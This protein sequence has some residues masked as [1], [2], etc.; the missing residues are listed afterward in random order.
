VVSSSS[1]RNF[2]A[3]AGA[4]WCLF[5]FHVCALSAQESIRQEAW[6][7]ADLKYSNEQPHQN[8][9]L[10]GLHALGAYDDNVLNNNQNRLGDSI[11]EGGG[12]LGFRILRPRGKM[13]ITYRPTFELHRQF[14][15]NDQFSH[16]AEFSGEYK[17]AP[18]FLVN[19]SDAFSYR[20]GI[21]QP[22]SNG[23]T[24]FLPVVPGGLNG[25]VLVPLVRELTNQ[26]RVG[27]KFLW[28]RRSA[29]DFVGT[30]SR[31]DFENGQTVLGKLQNTRGYG[32]GAAYQYRT[33]QATTLGLRY[34]Y[35]DLRFGQGSQALIHS[36]YLTLGY[37]FGERNVSL[38]FFGGPQFA[39]SREMPFRNST[40]PTTPAPTSL[41]APVS[42]FHHDVGG[43]ATFTARSAKTVFRISLLRQLSDGGGVV[44]LTRDSSEGVEFRRRLGRGFDLVLDGTNGQST[45]FSD[46]FGRGAIRSQSAGIAFEYPLGNGFL[47]HVGYTYIRQRIGGNIPFAFDLDRNRAALGFFYQQGLFP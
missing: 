3:P 13:L 21:I 8:A 23:N 1:F 26:A 32:G 41:R 43:G 31:R 17:L 47:F 36:G 27:A 42:T 7:Q 34:L 28:S 19:A 44:A 9:F 2:V 15:G 16:G 11:L 6:D 20:K 30:Y 10:L 24:A 12:L 14:Q 29:F 22:S 18:H 5:L 38:E 35:Q 4:L 45:S 46:V 37:K 25:N 39:S 33:S 40:G